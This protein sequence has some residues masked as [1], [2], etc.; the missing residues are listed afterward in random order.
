VADADVYSFKRCVNGDHTVARQIRDG[1]R[2]RPGSDSAVLTQSRDTLPKVTVGIPVY[3]SVAMLARCIN[4]ATSQTMKNI[5]IIVVDDGSTDRGATV[6]EAMALDDRRIKVVGL[7]R[8][9]GKAHAMNVVAGLARGE[10]LAVLDAEDAYLPDRLE[11][12]VF[13]AEMRNV[14]MVADNLL[15]IDFAIGRISRT[16]F[17]TTGPSRVLAMPDFA[18]ST[19]AY[20]G[21]DF[22]VLK[23]IVRRRFIERSGISYYEQTRVAETFYYMLEFFAAGGRALLLSAPLYKWT[24]PD[25][26]CP[27]GFRQRDFR[28]ILRA[29]EHFA[30]EMRA[31][32]MMDLAAMLAARTR[33]Y[34]SMIFYLDARRSAAEGRWLR[35]AAEILFHPASYAPLASRVVERSRSAV[36]GLFGKPN[37]RSTQRIL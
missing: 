28:E 5:E 11:R 24:L 8:R 34:R 3:N 31:K 35:C 29:N 32:G 13:E 33:R 27:T 15:Y 1:R 17:D 30:A 12:L 7:P 22:G 4:S 23:P 18:R 37:Q 20:A 19:N 10:W 16:A 21:F 25:A 14:D 6:A 36:R 9:R 2:G 26:H